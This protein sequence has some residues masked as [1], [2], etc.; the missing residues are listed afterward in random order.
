MAGETTTGLASKLLTTAVS[1]AVI[2]EARDKAVVVNL[3]RQEDLQGAPAKAINIP[4]WPGTPAAGD[5]TEGTDASPA[6]I[7]PTDF[8]LTADEAGIAFEITDLLAESDIFSGLGE[9]VDYGSRTMIEK[10][11]SDLTALFAALNT[12]SSVGTTTVNL[13]EL[14]FLAALSVLEIARAPTPYNCVLHQRQWADIRDSLAS[15]T[16]VLWGGSSPQGTELQKTGLIAAPFGVD[17]YRT[18]QCPLS[19]TSDRVGAMFSRDAMGIAWK[20]RVRT[21]MDRNALGRSTYIVITA[22]Y[23]V[24][25]LV[26]AYGVPI[27]SDA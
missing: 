20:W 18:S 13:T 26:D 15:T 16:K 7:V 3:V 8:T 14:D 11:D 5:L 2:Q 1:R 25:E 23:G 12:A 27:L 10:I 17:I 19:G 6:S 4:M 21:E 22:A 9:Y 24:G